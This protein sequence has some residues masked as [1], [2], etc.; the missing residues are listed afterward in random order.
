MVPAGST[1]GEG[2]NDMFHPDDQEPARLRWMQSLQTGEPYEIEYRLRHRSGVYRW[3]LGRAMPIRNEA[4][5]I[6]RWFGTCTDI[7]DLKMA[8]FG[9]T[10]PDWVEAAG[11]ARGADDATQ[12]NWVIRRY[13]ML[14]G[15]MRISPSPLFARRAASAQMARS[16]GLSKTS[17]SDVRA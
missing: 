17:P 15:R 2:W 3:T 6:T 12:W 13:R 16:S 14:P 8:G 10:S 5:E 4:G 1:D 11:I 9:C 7:D